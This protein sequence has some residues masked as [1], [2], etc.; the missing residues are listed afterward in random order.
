LTIALTVVGIFGVV[1]HEVARR[2]REVGIR[3]ALGADGR[4]VRA[5]VLKRSTVPAVLG[6]IAGAGTALWSTRGLGSVLVGLAPDDPLSFAV[7]AVTVIALVAAA[8]AIPAWRA[9]RLNP[10]TVL[11]AD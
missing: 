11:R 5:L 7:A 9:S 2:T 6:V 1:N 8:S 3:M 10:T 4:R